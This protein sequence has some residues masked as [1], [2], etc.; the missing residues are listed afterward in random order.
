[1]LRDP[2]QI[3]HAAQHMLVWDVNVTSATPSLDEPTMLDRLLFAFDD[4]KIDAV[5]LEAQQKG[6]YGNVVRVPA[7]LH[8][9]LNS[10]ETP[11]AK[12]IEQLG[13]L[14][15]ITDGMDVGRGTVKSFGGGTL[16]Y[17]LNPHKK[18]EKSM[19]GIKKLQQSDLAILLLR[20]HQANHLEGSLEELFPTGTPAS[21]PQMKLL[22]TWLKTVCDSEGGKTVWAHAHSEMVYDILQVRNIVDGTHNGDHKQ[23]LL[24]LMEVVECM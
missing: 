5:R 19:D 15:V 12:W 24:G 20:H 10:F 3:V 16:A 9:G 4:H 22:F 2:S 14:P 23:S 8:W 13:M 7:M 1:M 18:F 21:S 6:R 17:F 11:V